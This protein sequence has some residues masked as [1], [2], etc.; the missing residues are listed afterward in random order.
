MATR[1][2]DLL[3]RERRERLRERRDRSSPVWEESFRYADTIINLINRGVELEQLRDPLTNG[4]VLHYW[5]AGRG[6]DNSHHQ[7]ESLTVIKLLVDNGADLLAQDVNGFTPIL[8]A[9]NGHLGQRPNLK[10]LDFLLETYYFNQLEKIEA[11]ELAGAVILGDA[12]NAPIYYKA[13]EYW[14]HA[15]HLRNIRLEDG[16]RGPI[17]KTMLNLESVRTTEW[18]SLTQLEHV[19][20]HPD[21]YVMQCVPRPTEDRYLQGLECCSKFVSYFLPARSHLSIISLSR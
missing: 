7:E 10:V 11:L 1:R 20:E 5:A 6:I 19:I 4:T 8:C 16:R 3:E 9:A 21:D 18:T 2:R 15:L 13:F 14:R 12:G 17:Q